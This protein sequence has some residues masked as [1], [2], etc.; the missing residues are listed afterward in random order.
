[1]RTSAGRSSRVIIPHRPKRH[2]RAVARAVFILERIV[3][4]TFRWEFVD[5]C[6]L[7]NVPKVQ[8]A[9]YC[10]WHNRLALA[11]A[12]WRKFVQ[13]K[14][15]ERRLAALVSASRDGALLA[16]ILENF[17]VQPVRGSTSRRGPQALL[18]LTTWAER[19]WDLA[20]TPDGP[21]G[22]REVVQDG[23]IALGQLTGLPIV[24]VTA[25]IR[26]KVRLRSWDRFE[27]PLP[28][29]HCK[30]IF[31]PPIFVPR[32]ADDSE[33]EASRQRL[34]ERLRTGTNLLPA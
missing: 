8:P 3:T 29:A 4:S 27:L 7:F 6:G 9:I 15:P 20:I 14:Q 18:E 19:G 17:G 2:Q 10:V 12:I 11:M 16:Q 31:Y 28:L 25:L 24:P 21:R 32:T 1:M 13:R 5:H 26:G 23:V 33:R 30:V 34:E 22:P